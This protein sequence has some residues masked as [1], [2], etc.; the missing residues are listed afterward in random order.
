MKLVRRNKLSCFEPGWSSAEGV[1]AGFTT[2]NGG[3]SRPPYNSLNL[4]FNTDD[5]PAHVEG[6]RATLSRTFGL[7]PHLLLTVSQVHG[8]D[9]LLVDTPNLDLAHFAQVECDAIITN[10][11]GI[12]IGV[13]VADCY[14]VLIHDPVTRVVAAVHAGWRG[15]ANGII[16]KTVAAMCQHFGS[17]VEN[18]QAAIGPGIGAHRYEV[19][20]PVRDAFRAGSGHWEEIAEETRL[21]YWK[22]DLRAS[23]RLQ[24]RDA[25]LDAAAIEAAEECTCCHRELFFSYRRDSGE[26]GR[27]L[28][29]IGLTQPG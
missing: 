11:P 22:L 19:D 7:P 28:G 24:L 4:A 1:I 14:P 17:R 12:L 25:G 15:A 2:R 26:T 3:V 18:L 6:N 5:L 20:R 29:F 13:L 16:A 9:L 27:Q 21:G 10:Q 23:C 8:N